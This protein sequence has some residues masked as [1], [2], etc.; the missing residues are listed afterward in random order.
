MSKIKKF[1]SHSIREKYEDKKMVIHLTK[2]QL[3]STYDP[4][5][6]HKKP[7]SIFDNQK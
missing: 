2:E 7:I 1:R 3:D 5:N 4:Y 6:Y